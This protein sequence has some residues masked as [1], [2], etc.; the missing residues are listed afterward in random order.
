VEGGLAQ[1]DLPAG[2][3]LVGLPRGGEA[4]LCRE[5]GAEVGELVVQGLGAG[6][7]GEQV[8]QVRVEGLARAAAGERGAQPPA[9]G[10]L[11]V[12]AVGRVVAGAVAVAVAAADEGEG[13]GAGAGGEEAASAQAGETFVMHGCSLG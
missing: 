13:G 6:G 11:A 12:A 10:G 1:G 3:G 4:G 9:L 8:G 5:V 7:V 2:E